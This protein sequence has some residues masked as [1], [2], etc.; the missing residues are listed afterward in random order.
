MV[1]LRLPEELLVW[2]TE[3]AEARGVSRTELLASA[4]V[5]FREDCESGVP[6]LRQAARA[7]SSVRRPDGE[8]VGDCPDRPGE[9]GHVWLPASEDG[10]RPCRFCGTPG[11]GDAVS[12][13][14]GFFEQATKSRAEL[15]ATLRAPD[16][17]FGRKKEK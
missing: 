9:L 17:A 14:E 4:L 2:A 8:G 6:E 10:R 11:R 5:S 12:R 13:E 7:S 3:Y 16:S 1:S 15:F